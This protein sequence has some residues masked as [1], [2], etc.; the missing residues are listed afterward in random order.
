M[1]NRST[2]MYLSNT[3]NYQQI[4]CTIYRSTGVLCVTIL[5]DQSSGYNDMARLH[6]IAVL[7]LG[8]PGLM[9]WILV[10][11]MSQ[12]GAVLTTRPVDLQSSVLPLCYGCPLHDGMGKRL[13]MA[14]KLHVKTIVAKKSQPGFTGVRWIIT[15]TELGQLKLQLI[16]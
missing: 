2:I 13:N 15:S 6:Y 8:Q 9:R 16:C 4:S 1:H 3:R 10:W 14:E 11:I 7:V 5:V 12:A